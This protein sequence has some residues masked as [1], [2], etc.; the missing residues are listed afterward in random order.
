MTPTFYDFSL[1]MRMHLTLFAHNCTLNISDNSTS[2]SIPSEYKYS[3]RLES[4]HVLKNLHVS[5]VV[6]EMPRLCP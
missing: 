5:I 1:F 3:G 4:A 2:Q 6:K